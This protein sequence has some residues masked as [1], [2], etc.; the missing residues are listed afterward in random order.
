M[1]AINSFFKINSP[2]LFSTISSSAVLLYLL[3][4][5]GYS[6]GFIVFT[7]ISAKVFKVYRFRFRIIRNLNRRFSLSGLTLT[8]A[9]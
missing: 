9:L 4:K 5:Q 2:S 7:V 8:G 3:E 1:S 6:K